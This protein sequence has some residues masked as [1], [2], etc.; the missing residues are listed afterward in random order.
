M[1]V[2]VRN[3]N[4]LIDAEAEAVRRVELAI[5]RAKLPE[6]TSRRAASTIKTLIYVTGSL[7]SWTIIMVCNTSVC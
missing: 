2:C 7:I 5:T 1:V 6:L 3:D 4:V